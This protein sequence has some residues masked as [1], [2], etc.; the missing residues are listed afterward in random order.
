MNLNEFVLNVGEDAKR[1]RKFGTNML[2]S[3][4]SINSHSMVIGSSG[5]GKSVFSEIKRKE[6]RTKGRLLVDTQLYREGGLF[7]YEY[8]YARRIADGVR[9]ALPRCMRGKAATFIS[10][11]SRPRKTKIKYP[12]LV[13]TP[14]GIELDRSLVASAINA[15]ESQA[16]IRLNQP[17]IIQLMSE[18]NIDETLAEYG[19]AETQIRESLCEA[20]S[21]TLIG[22]TWP[23]YGDLHNRVDKSASSFADELDAAARK[24]GYKVNPCPGVKKFKFDASVFVQKGS[25]LASGEWPD[26][27]RLNIQTLRQFHPELAEWGDLAIGGAFGDYSQDVLEVSWA[28]WLLESRDETF[29]N[30]CCWRQTRGKWVL[31]LD[32]ETLAQANEWKL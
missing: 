22:K 8:E 4:E 12:D 24:A 5:S 25:E 29:L 27:Y 10:D 23:R 18:H 28:D 30:Y 3:T 21:M 26:E 15:L 32:E 14:N 2:F 13:T 20:L 6:A 17:Q 16:G 19:E 7:P 9:G 1:N 31:G 11:V